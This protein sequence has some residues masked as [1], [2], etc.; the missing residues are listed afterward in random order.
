MEQY[1]QAGFA[2]EYCT[3]AEAITAWNTRADLCADRVQALEAENVWLRQIM[4]SIESV[5]RH[6]KL[7]DHDLVDWMVGAARAALSAIQKENKT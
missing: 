5:P 4:S 2:A 6:A 7:A 1:E 3:K